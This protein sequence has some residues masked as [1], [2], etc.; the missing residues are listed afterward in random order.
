MQRQ[1]V[2]ALVT[3]VR[4]SP[5]LAQQGD[6]SRGQREFRVCAACAQP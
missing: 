5:V 4:A 3:M 6:A 1:I 2:T